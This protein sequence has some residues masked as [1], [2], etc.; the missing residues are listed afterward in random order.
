[1]KS[2]TH[3]Q[4]R[5]QHNF[6][7]VMLDQTLLKTPFKVHTNWVVIT[8]SACT[9]KTTLINM[10]ADKG[11]PIIQETAR[12][13]IDQEIA[14]GQSIEHIIKNAQTQ[15]AII[16]MQ[17]QAENEENVKFSELAFLDRGLP[18]SLTFYRYNGLNPNAILMK[19]F[20]KRYACV[21]ILNRLPLKLDGARIPDENFLHYLDQWLEKDYR[22]LGY[23]VVRVPVMP[24]EERLDFILN[25][26]SQQRVGIQ[27]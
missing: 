14:K 24:P 21:F 6:Q 18:D 4:D 25:T 11:F 23:Q 1:M 15:L 22:S 17:I 12:L 26:L 19:C 16:K 8:G 27:T 3:P 20:Q 9:G 13:Y 7:A 2:K 5:N 10:L